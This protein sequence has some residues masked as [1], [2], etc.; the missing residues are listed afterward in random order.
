M[1]YPYM[2]VSSCPVCHDKFVTLYVSRYQSP[3]GKFV[4]I[5]FKSIKNLLSVS[6]YCSL[7]PD[8]RNA[9]NVE[10]EFYLSF[11]KFRNIIKIFLN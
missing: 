1:F 3:S 9:S 11:E 2:N 6:I 4:S 7:P 10:N 5:F 8:K